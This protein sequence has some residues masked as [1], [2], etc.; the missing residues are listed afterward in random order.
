MRYLVLATDYDGTLAHDGVTAVE[1]IAAVERFRASGGRP[2]L[3]TG[4]E[5]PDLRRTFDRLDLFERVVAENGGLLYDPATR[6]ERLLGAAPD[7][8]LVDL[9]QARGVSP[10]SIG[11][12]IIATV[13]PWEQV[14]L[15]GIRTLG[16]ELQVIFNKGAVMILPSGVNKATGLCA[17]LDELCLSAH[18]VVGVGDAEND[19]ALLD[20]CELSVAVANAI[21]TLKS[22]ADV[23]TAGARGAGV[24]ELIDR[25]LASP[26]DVT[27]SPRRHRFAIG[28]MEG[29]PVDLEPVGHRLLVSG[30]SGA[31]KSTLTNTLLEQLATHRYQ[32]CLIDPEGDYDAFARAIRIGSTHA[33]PDVDEVIGALKRPDQNVIVSLTGVTKADRP[34]YFASLLPR[35]QELRAAYGRPHWLVIDEAHHVLPADWQLAAGLIPQS[36]SSLALVT[37]EPDLVSP[38]ARRDLDVIVAVGQVLPE[39]STLLRE[40]QV[41]AAADSL[42]PG[43]ARLWHVRDGGGIDHV[44][45]PQTGGTASPAPPEVW[46]GG[47]V[48]GNP[49]RVQRPRRTAAPGGAEPQRV[50][51]ARPRGGRRHLELPPA[52]RRLLSVVP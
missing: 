22:R 3:V 10:L 11:R 9:M 50:P 12:T 43:V 49:V 36:W 5:L 6:R 39:L 2:I 27:L 21:P 35:V 19:H 47:A 16:L 37:L 24:A 42:E 38:L 14:A 33:S 52:A 8:R 41:E 7:P 31:G 30:P 23:V 26:L 51:P 17:A 4:R 28:E 29:R 20:T 45:R 40:H 32:F 13:E 18:N 1:T 46:R 25:L 34:A 15:E 48:A 44:Q